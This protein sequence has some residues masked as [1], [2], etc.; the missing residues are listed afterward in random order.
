MT[1]TSGAFSPLYAPGLRKVFFGEHD[2]M[3][4]MEFER[5]MNVETS[6]RQYEDDYEMAPIGTFQVKAEGT[7]TVFVDP[8][9]GTTKR[10]TWTPWSLGVRA[11]KESIDDDLYDKLAKAMKRLAVSAIQTQEIL[12]VAPLNNAFSTAAV[13]FKADEALCATAHTLLNAGAATASNRHASD[14]ALAVASLQSLRIIMENTVD[15]AGMPIPLIPTTLVTPTNLMMVTKEILQ[16]VGKPFENSNT[17]NVLKGDFGSTTNHYLTS[18]TAYF[19]LAANHDMKVFKR[20]R[21]EFTNGDDFTTGD[22]LFKGY[23]REGSGWS[24]WRGV[25]GSPGA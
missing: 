2:S 19:L 11:T 16:A 24:E 12:G 8:V 20:N 6:T 9:S 1:I 17:P 13:G 22:A 18:T 7:P 21:P 14:A 3:I 25:A 4:P 10:Y 5:I 15:E 23:L